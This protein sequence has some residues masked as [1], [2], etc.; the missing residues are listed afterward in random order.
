MFGV[1]EN[2]YLGRGVSLD[3]EVTVNKESIKGRFKV[4]NQILE[5]QINQFMDHYYL[6]RQID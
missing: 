5:I 4:R 6:K 2:N 1:T 3:A